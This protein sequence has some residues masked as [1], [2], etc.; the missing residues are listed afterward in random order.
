MPDFSNQ[1]RV[2][3]D[4][5]PHASR[6]VGILRGRLL[7]DLERMPRGFILEITEE[8]GVVNRIPGV[9]L[10]QA[11]DQITADPTLIGGMVDILC[12]PRTVKKDLTI[13]AV[14]ITPATGRF[15]PDQDFFWITGTRMKTRAEGMVKLGIRPNR[16]KKQTS[17]HFEKF[18]LEL[19][20][21]L[22]DDSEGVFLVKAVRR[23][24]RLFVVES[25]PRPTGNKTTNGTASPKPRPR[26]SE[27]RSSP[28]PVN[29]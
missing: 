21:H 8:S 2:R 22:Q 25:S 6:A 16:T 13:Q 23:G 18:W 3:R 24:N 29:R 11:R 20:G 28:Q 26:P 1:I 27:A 12:Y 15:N 19:Y 4:L 7:P 17:H 9:M 14:Q 10:N 5:T